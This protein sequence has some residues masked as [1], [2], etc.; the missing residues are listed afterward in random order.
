MGKRIRNPASDHDDHVNH[1]HYNDDYRSSHDDGSSSHDNSDYEH[2]NCS[3][4]T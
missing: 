1:Y 4:M 3:C 2:S